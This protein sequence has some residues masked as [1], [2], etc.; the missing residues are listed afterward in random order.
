M[1]SSP[2][3][4]IIIYYPTKREGLKWH[5]PQL[6]QNLPNQRKAN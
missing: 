3:T 1:S 4:K 6:F 2:V 5:N